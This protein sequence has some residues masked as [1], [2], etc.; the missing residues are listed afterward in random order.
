MVSRRSSK[1][2]VPR[3]KSLAKRPEQ[4]HGWAPD[5]LSGSQQRLNEKKSAEKSAILGVRANRNQQK[6]F[7]V[8]VPHQIMILIERLPVMLFGRYI[9]WN[10][11]VND[12][13]SAWCVDGLDDQITGWS[14]TA[15][16]QDGAEPL[17]RK[18]ETMQVG[19][20]Q[21]T[22]VLWFAPETHP[23]VSRGFE[24]EIGSNRYITYV[25]PGLLHTIALAL[26]YLAV[27]PRSI[28]QQ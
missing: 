10:S 16:R 3:A 11:Q 14:G 18:Q 5:S 24:S 6:K 1:H 13:W 9:D 12:V 23:S 7:P 17:W 15:A 27:G 20:E 21:W 22:P 2:V 26:A 19:G 28:I 4:F 25:K 8:D